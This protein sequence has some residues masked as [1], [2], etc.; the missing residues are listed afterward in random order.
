MPQARSMIGR[1]D[2]TPNVQKKL[3]GLASPLRS[4]SAP[5]GLTL[6]NAQFSPAATT[7]TSQ[8]TMRATFSRATG[9][10]DTLVDVTGT[11][12]AITGAVNVARKQGLKVSRAHLRYLN[13]FPRNLGEVLARFDKVLLPEM[14]L[15]QLALL[16]RARFLKDVI[17]Y[18]K[19]EGKPFYRHEILSRIRELLGAGPAPAE[20]GAS[21]AG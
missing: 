21:H 9:D 8:L 11:A 6:A 14:N 7:G 18:S 16:L 1:Q 13:P 3:L 15:G 20:Q 2:T 4:S 12:G 19:V 10:Q 17:T 5:P